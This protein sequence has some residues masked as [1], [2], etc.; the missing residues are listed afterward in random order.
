MCRA[1]G[2]NEHR[3][4]DGRKVTID[5]I[6]EESGDHQKVTIIYSEYSSFLNN[7]E[8]RY[9]HLFDYNFSSKKFLT[10][11]NSAKKLSIAFEKYYDSM[12]STS[13][14]K[15]MQAYSAALTDY[16]P[17]LEKFVIELKAELK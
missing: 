11:T 10:F 8:L 9:G 4:R 3:T 12:Y 13:V 5:D 14:I 1:G 17:L 15:Y 7:F 2:K 6:Q 16:L